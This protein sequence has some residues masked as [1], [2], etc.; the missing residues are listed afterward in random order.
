[1]WNSWR[2]LPFFLFFFLL[3]MNSFGCLNYLQ[4][5]ES[6][7]ILFKSVPECDPLPPTSEHRYDNFFL[8]ILSSTYPEELSS[9]VQDI[10]DYFK[11]DLTG[12]EVFFSCWILHM[13][14]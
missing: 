2:F 14:F 7:A 5:V 1:M 13:H 9:R 11:I 8:S 10:Y 12:F 4:V 6:G 3:D